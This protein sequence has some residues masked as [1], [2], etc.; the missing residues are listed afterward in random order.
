[1]TIKYNILILIGR[2]L[3]VMLFATMLIVMMV[4]ILSGRKFDQL[5][6]VFFVFFIFS[7]F[8]VFI[9]SFVHSIL[10]ETY[11]ITIEGESLTLHRPVIATTR[12]V[13]LRKIK[14]F[15]KSEIKYG[16]EWGMSLFKSQSIIIYT[17][18]FGPMELISYNYWE[19]GEIENKFQELGLTYLGQE[20]YKT[21]LF[22]RKYEF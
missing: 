4:S 7:V 11:S 8:S 2:V 19:F 6:F 18:E 22:F 20:E 1:M 16:S 10:R 14:G 13:D 17:N 15:S 5:F 12:F 9:F 3:C 21:G